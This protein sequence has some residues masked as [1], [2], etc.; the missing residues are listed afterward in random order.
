M[1][2]TASQAPFGRLRIG[3]E[4]ARWQVVEP[5]AVLQV[6][7]GVLDLGV[8]AVVGLE[9]QG[10][11]LP[12]GD[13]GVIAVVGEQRQLGAGR[14]LHPADDEPHRRGVGLGVERRIGGLSHV[15][16]PVHPIGDGRPVFLGYGLD[17][18]AQ[19]LVLEK[20]TSILRQTATM[21]WA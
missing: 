6:A 19:A 17:E 14:G 10:V 4:T 9:S 3:G 16:V 15:V 1:T 21:A 5:D 18:L 11:A 8:A 20:R 7:D 12:S 2:W 13:E